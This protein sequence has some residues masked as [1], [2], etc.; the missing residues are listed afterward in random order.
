[1]ELSHHRRNNRTVVVLQNWIG[2]YAMYKTS[3]ADEESR[4]KYHRK[5]CYARVT[6]THAISHLCSGMHCWVL[7][8]PPAPRILLSMHH[9]HVSSFIPQTEIFFHIL[10]SC[11]NSCIDQTEVCVPDAF[12]VRKTM[13]LCTTASDDNNITVREWINWLDGSDDRCR[14]WF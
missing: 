8:S 10:F 1:M 4:E 14:R 9:P 12:V 2:C 11:R 13:N 3:P 5:W 6:H 7:T